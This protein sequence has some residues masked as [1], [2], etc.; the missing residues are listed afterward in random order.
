VAANDRLIGEVVQRMPET[1]GPDSSTVARIERERNAALE[2]FKWD[3][4][5]I[6]LQAAM[7][8]LD[9]EAEE[10]HELVRDLPTADDARRFLRDLPYLWEA[11]DLERRQM[12]ARAIFE[13]IEVLGVE[14]VR[15]I[16]TREALDNGWFDAW[17]GATLHI[18][19]S[20][21][22]VR[23]GRGER[24]SAIL[25]HLRVRPRFLLEN[26][27]RPRRVWP[28]HERKAG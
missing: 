3:R 5:L 11:A 6:G 19:L 21:E 25:A 13:R 16:P 26:V 17:A 9:R 1:S 24:D 7:T 18:P 8:R 15:I 20:P 10:A 23:Y 28:I 2:R 4:D 22:S 12:L 14:T 27:T